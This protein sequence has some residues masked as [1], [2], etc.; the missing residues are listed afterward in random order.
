M[1]AKLGKV[2][3]IR[4]GF[5]CF[6][7]LSVVVPL[8]T[9]GSTDFVFSGCAQ[10]ATQTE[11]EGLQTLFETL[12]SRASTRNFSRSSLGTVSGLFQCR[13]DL[14]SPSDCRDC[15]AEA[16]KQVEK[17]CKVADPPAARIQLQGCYLSYEVTGGGPATH[18]SSG[19]VYHRCGP[20]IP[21][22]NST[23]SGFGESQ[24]VEAIHMSVNQM[25]NGFFA[26]Y[27]STGNGSVM[28]AAQCEGDM[29]GDKCK[30]CVNSAA[31]SLKS[32]CGSASVSGEMYFE[33]CYVTYNLNGYTDGSPSSSGEPFLNDIMTS[34][35]VAI[36]IGLLFGGLMLLMILLYL[37][38]LSKKD[39]F[40]R[41]Y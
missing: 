21:A 33:K 20:E 24:G 8:V 27:V 4:N 26:G 28:V 19:M 13:G 34:K 36:L 31:E 18:D 35:N 25:V 39:P 16:T 40:V 10:Y 29:A 41:K 23:E 3:L 1:V 22:V 38:S 17:R 14:W 5:T 9:A 30:G 12:K 7:V 32:S 11:S 2:T 6:A 15:V 37:K